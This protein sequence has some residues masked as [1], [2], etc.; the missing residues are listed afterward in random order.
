MAVL[1]L[2]TVLS[3]YGLAVLAD[4]AGDR[5]RRRQLLF[6]L[7]SMAVC[8]WFTSPARLAIDTQR[9]RRDLHVHMALRYAKAERFEDALGEY[10]AALRLLPEPEPGHPEHLDSRIRHHQYHQAAHQQVP[11]EDRV[12]DG[13]R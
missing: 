9:M 2:L 11:E 6:L 12:P 4:A 3:V 13:A 5:D 8:F 1:P 7:P 10:G